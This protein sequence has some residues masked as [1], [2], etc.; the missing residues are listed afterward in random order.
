V[1]ESAKDSE[2]LSTSHT[3]T[4]KCT[5]ARILPQ[6][7]ETPAESCWCVSSS[8]KFQP[9]VTLLQQSPNLA[10]TRRAQNSKPLDRHPSDNTHVPLAKTGTARQH[11]VHDRALTIVHTFQRA[12][13]TPRHDPQ[14]RLS[15]GWHILYTPRRLS[16]GRSQSKELLAFS[17]LP[18]SF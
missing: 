10:R 6:D 3:V 15:H 4:L 17:I 13:E 11:F 16:H 12:P 14:S 1:V 8:S 7:S 9:S 2:G 18:I 5:S